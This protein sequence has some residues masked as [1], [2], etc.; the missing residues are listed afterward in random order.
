[1]LQILPMALAQVKTC[2]TFENLLYEIRQIIYCFYE[3]KKKSL[4]KYIA[5]QWIQQKYNTKMNI[6]F[7]NS[8]NS[9]TSDPHS[10]FVPTAPS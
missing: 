10:P 6:I 4:K 5:I 9:K 1:M 8:K 2:N 3:A 7:M